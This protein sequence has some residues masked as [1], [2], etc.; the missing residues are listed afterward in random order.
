M[1]DILDAFGLKYEELTIDERDDLLKMVNVMEQQQS[2]S[3]EDIRTHI[4]D[5]LQEVMLALAKEPEGT[6]NNIFLK[7]RMLNYSMLLGV[8][9]APMKARAEV[10]AYIQN[11]K[12][13]GKN[14]R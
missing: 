8:L 3:L 9:E 2:L 7:A 11:M 6:T 10:E 12:Q 1:D 4:K 13:A 5:S 14:R